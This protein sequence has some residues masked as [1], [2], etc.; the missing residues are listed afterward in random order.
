MLK[1]FLAVAIVATATVLTAA[2]ASAQVKYPQA[3]QPVY[4]P[5]SAAHLQAQLSGNPATCGEVVAKA[6]DSV[7]L[8][9]QQNS[10]GGESRQNVNAMLLAAKNAAAVGDF[11]SCW[12]WYDRSQRVVR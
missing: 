12:H 1:S 4:T 10:P 6:R 11:D 5:P 3:N 9:I 8:R 2:G 7:S